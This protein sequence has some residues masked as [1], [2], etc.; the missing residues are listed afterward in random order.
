MDPIVGSHHQCFC[1]GR[2]T[3]A[4]RSRSPAVQGTAAERARIV[5]RVRS[6]I[7]R[8]VIVAETDIHAPVDLASL[9]A[10]RENRSWTF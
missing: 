8:D 1:T 7:R 3:L 6:L 10:D 4:A 9:V 2:D 5:P